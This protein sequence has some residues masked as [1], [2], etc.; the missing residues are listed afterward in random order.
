M[1]DYQYPDTLLPPNH[2]TFDRH[3]EQVIRRRFDSLPVEILRQFW[4]PESCPLHLLPHLARQYSVDIWREEWSEERKRAVVAASPQLH[5]IKGTRAAIELALESYGQRFDLT[6]WWEGQA[7]SI[8]GYSPEYC[9]AWLEIDGETYL[10]S[11]IAIGDL[12]ASLRMCKRLTLHI[13]VGIAFKVSS[14]LR[15]S[16]VFAPTLFMTS[17][18]RVIDQP[19]RALSHPVAPSVFTASTMSQTTGR[20]L[21]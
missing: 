8:P 2:T 10:A 14:H 16:S 18:G 19:T 15:F 7:Q 4:H 20:V 11:G 21:H 13:N 3:I 5:R 12:I 1:T 6:E 9:T 17:A